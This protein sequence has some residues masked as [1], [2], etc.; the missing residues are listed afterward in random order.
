MNEGVVK[1]GN[2][3][4]RPAAAIKENEEGKRG[5]QTC[6]H[7]DLRSGRPNGPAHQLRGECPPIRILTLYSAT[8]GPQGA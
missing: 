7:G 3:P 1:R 6:A 5:G 2:S 8:A 4:E